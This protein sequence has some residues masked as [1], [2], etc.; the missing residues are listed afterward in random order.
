MVL[1][2][3]RGGEFG[4]TNGIRK[5]MIGKFANIP[6]TDILDNKIGDIPGDDNNTAGSENSV[7][8]SAPGK[9]LQVLLSIDEP[10]FGG[11]KES[12]KVLE[13]FKRAVLMVTKWII[14]EDTGRSF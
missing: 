6:T 13:W 4:K 5:R 2:M 14:Q 11:R 8:R 3:I 1:M 9:V 10:P 7:T 12:F